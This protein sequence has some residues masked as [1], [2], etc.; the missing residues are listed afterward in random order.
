[1]WMSDD[2]SYQSSLSKMSER[3]GMMKLRKEVVSLQVA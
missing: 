3:E 1:M 2:P